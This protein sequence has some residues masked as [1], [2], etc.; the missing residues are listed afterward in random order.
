MQSYKKPEKPIF[1]AD[2]HLGDIAKYLR[3]AGYDTLFPPPSSGRPLIDAALRDRRILLSRSSRLPESP[4]LWRIAENDPPEI[5]TALTRRF[6]LEIFYNPFSRCTV[7]NTPL[8]MRK[9][10]DLPS[11][12]PPG[13][14]SRFTEFRDC[15]GCGR[16]YWKG[17]HYRRM[18]AFWQ[19]IFR[20][21]SD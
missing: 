13:V 3:F 7:C 2:S 9:L 8:E 1:I 11:P 21:L 18:D 14:R 5:L 12:V 15:P 17:D 4:Y 10:S 16:V 6:R 20:K 19:T